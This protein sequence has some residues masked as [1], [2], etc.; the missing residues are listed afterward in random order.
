ME[1]EQEITLYIQEVLN[2]KAEGTV[3]G[4]LISWAFSLKRVLILNWISLTQ[5]TLNIG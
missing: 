5:K 4:S 3:K 1:R 2:R